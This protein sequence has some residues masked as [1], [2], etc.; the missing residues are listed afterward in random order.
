MNVSLSF[1]NA[2]LNSKH[3]LEE[4]EKGDSFDE[5]E[6]GDSLLRI[7]HRDAVSLFR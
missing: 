4:F 5:L 3:E 7:K 2:S 1:A 6:E